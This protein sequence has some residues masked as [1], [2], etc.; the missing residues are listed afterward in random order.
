MRVFN[1]Y[2]AR[3]FI[4][5]FLIFFIAT[6]TVAQR[7]RIKIKVKKPKITIGSPK[8]D[9]PTPEAV[10]KNVINT[11]EIAINQA[12]KITNNI[13]VVTTD[14]TKDISKTLSKAGEDAIKETGRIPNHIIDV[15][16]AT[17]NYVS[18]IGSSTITTI[19]DAEQRIKQ[20]KLVDAFF[21]LALSPLQAQEEAAFKATQDSGWINSIGAVAASAYGGPGGSAAYASWQTY[22]LSGNNMELAI[23]AGL[24]AGLTNAANGTVTKME[25]D[26]I[27]NVILGGAI[28]GAAMAASGSDEE[29]IIRGIYM[30]GSMVLVQD[31]YQ[32]YLGTG[33]NSKAPTEP[34][35][36][37]SLTD[38]SCIELRKAYTF[39]EKG[40]VTSFDPTKLNPNRVHVGI[41]ADIETLNR[42][43][44]GEKLSAEQI[45][46]F[47]EINASLD[48][49][50]FMQSVAKTPAIN[51]MAFFH[52]KWAVDWK[53]G[54]LSTKAT[55]IPAIALTYVGTG[56][57][58]YNSIPTE[59]VANHSQ[60][61]KIPSMSVDP[62]TIKVSSEKEIL[63]DSDNK[64]LIEV[65]SE[66]KPRTVWDALQDYQN[67]LPENYERKAQLTPTFVALEE[68]QNVLEKRTDSIVAAN[69]GVEKILI[70]VVKPSP[71]WVW[72][73]AVNPSKFSVEK[74]EGIEIDST[75]RIRPKNG[76]EWN[77]RDNPL[78]LKVKKII[79]IEISA[80]TKNLQ[81]AI[82]WVWRYPD[83][84][85]NLEV[86]KE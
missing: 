10:A 28:G 83:Q 52:D 75:G 16:N 20:G 41:Q 33:L 72:V 2:F 25:P 70:D 36:C 71:G 85:D 66:T 34:P 56:A 58:L 24:I 19:T 65:D 69:K 40:E 5:G 3:F 62:A 12:G 1:N 43:L 8:I 57:Q 77:E 6:P 9:V 32:S 39:N 31:A 48:R 21:H 78:N 38:A 60:E 11:T 42:Y 15:G 81:P 47:N 49:S 63:I 45:A 82:G 74:M 14:A 55:I 35:Y 17:V 76:W 86:I 23:R 68:Y 29:S 79:G 54:E 53:M 4:T 27:R 50:T 44:N 84:V 64:L 46:K 51:S 37:M 26:L 59:I 30:G 18:S 22:R 67:N 13:T 7:L 61:V 73:D 80:D